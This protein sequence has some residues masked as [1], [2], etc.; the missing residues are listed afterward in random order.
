[1]KITDYSIS[2][3]TPASQDYPTLLKQ[4]KDPPQI[5]YYRGNLDPNLFKKSLAIVGSRRIT[6]YG[7][8]V[9]DLLIPSLVGSG[10]TIISGFMYGTDT[11]AHQKTLECGGKTVAV[12][13]GGLNVLYPPENEKLYGEIVGVG[14]PDPKSKNKNQ[15]GAETA[16]LQN[17]L[18]ISEYPPDQ[19]PQLWTFPQRNRIVAALATLG[20]LVIEAD[21]KSGSLIT[22]A[23]AAGLGRPVYAIPGP[24][25]SSVSVGTNKL[26]RDGVAKM[27]LGAGDIMGV[28]EVSKV[29]RVSRGDEGKTNENESQILELLSTEPLTIDE[30]ARKLASNIVTISQSVTM[31]SLKG[32]VE[33]RNGKYSLLE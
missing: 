9:L 6:N 28:L 7:E 25:T 4:L 2:K 19:Q 5:L 20:V 21:A 31:M 27:V 8:R 16:P 26:I 18:I 17:G 3:I 32:M 24:I 30:I 33:E 12:L 22:A 15:S 10:V 11:L 23:N 29:S 13:G 1:M 14:F